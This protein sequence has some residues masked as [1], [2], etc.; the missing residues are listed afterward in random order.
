MVEDSLQI[1]AEF[2]TNHMGNFNVLLKMVDHIASIKGIS[3]I[4]MQKKNVEKFYSK[5]K[6]ESEYKSPYGKTYRDYRE[7]F[8]FSTW[9]YLTFN[10][11]CKEK[12]VK[13]FVTV[14]DMES[15]NLMLQFGLDL[16]KIASCNSAAHDFIKEVSHAVP[17]DKSIVVSVAGRTLN[18]IEKILSLIPNHN[19]FI[20]HCVAEYPCKHENLKLGNIEVLIEKFQDDRIKI[21]YSGHEESIIP[22]IAAANMGISMLE[23]H[24]CLSRH[25]FVH[26]I[27]C[28]LEPYEFDQMIRAIRNKDMNPKWHSYLPPIS[29]Q[30]EFGMSEMERTFLIENKYG[31]QYLK[32]KSEF[33]CW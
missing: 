30:S 7:I 31:N 11:Y 32:D 3:Y 19:L 5:E 27:D 29:F 10:N 17:K 20:L 8:E 1:I 13:W 28:S 14:Q 24:F 2:T 4:K 6:L 9:D 22:S 16:Y 18:E 21:G 25:S 15:L 12:G 33:K 26:H 23:R